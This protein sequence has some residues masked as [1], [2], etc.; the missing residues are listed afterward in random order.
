MTYQQAEDLLIKTISKEDTTSQLTCMTDFYGDDF[1]RA[2]LYTQ[3]ASLQTQFAI[4]DQRKKNFGDILARLKAFSPAEHVFFSEVLKLVGIILVNPAT[5]AVSEWSF[6][7]MRRLKNY[8]R[9]TMGQSRL[10]AA[11][12]LHVH[13]NRTEQLSVI[14]LA[15]AFVSSEHRM[16]VFG[17]FSENEL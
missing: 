12:L 16:S 1:D 5:N 13:K 4:E 7:A 3:L 9:S 10:N 11:M 2:R 6:S 17:N 14:D 15:N 8:L